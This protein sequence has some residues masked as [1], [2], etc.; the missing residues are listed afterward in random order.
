VALIGLATRTPEPA[1]LA[2]F[3][4]A[5]TVDL[6]GPA[7]AADPARKTGSEVQ[8]ATDASDAADVTNTV[9]VSGAG[10][11]FEG[12]LI[13]PGPELMRSSLNSGTAGL[14]YAQ[15]SRTAF[16]RNTHAAISSGVVAAQAGAVMRQWHHALQALGR[17]PLLY[18]SGGG[19]PDVAEEMKSVLTDACRRAN[20]PL[21][22]P[23]WVET[24]VLDGLAALVTATAPAAPDGAHR[25]E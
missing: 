3:G 11:R 6:L 15:G 19:W 23:L 22:E 2:S 14:P 8:T 16:P 10:R 9:S 7:P 17:A 24:P 12:G 18:C 13:L 25:I 21:A 5:T 1:L 20:L 4:T